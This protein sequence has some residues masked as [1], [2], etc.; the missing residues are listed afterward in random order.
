M[1]NLRSVIGPGWRMELIET[2]AAYR[3]GAL[4]VHIAAV[5]RTWRLAIDQHAKA[6]H[7]AARRRICLVAAY[8]TRC[9]ATSGT[10]SRG[11]PMAAV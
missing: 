4:L 3:A 9:C 5:R 6:R 10:Q 1:V 7:G 2:L 11:K 8:Q